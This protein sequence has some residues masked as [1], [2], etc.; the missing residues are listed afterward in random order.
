VTGSFAI[1]PTFLNASKDMLLTWWVLVRSEKCHRSSLESLKE[2][3]FVDE[4]LG[5]SSSRSR[6]S[7]MR[8]RSVAPKVVAAATRSRMQEKVIIA[9]ISV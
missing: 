4:M 3:N 5:K 7:R 1:S 6:N 2:L 9:L 8:R